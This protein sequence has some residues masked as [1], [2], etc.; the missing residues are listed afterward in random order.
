[1][2]ESD[3]YAVAVIEDDSI[4]GHILRKISLVCLLFLW[5]GGSIA[6]VI[7]GT[8]RYSVDLPQGG[9]EIS[10]KLLFTGKPQEINKLQK[11]LKQ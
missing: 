6:C 4:V 7:T 10:C 2:N 1:M 11:L 8:R 5:R 9:L 3:R